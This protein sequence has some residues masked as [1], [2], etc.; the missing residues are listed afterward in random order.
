MEHEK[1]RN[2]FRPNLLPKKALLLYLFVMF[3]Q[4]VGKIK[5]QQPIHIKHNTYHVP[6]QGVISTNDL[7][8]LVCVIFQLNMEVDMQF[9]YQHARSEKFIHHIYDILLCISPRKLV[10]R[11][12]QYVKCLLQQYKIEGYLPYFVFRDVHMSRNIATKAPALA[13][14][15][16]QPPSSFAELLHFV[17]Y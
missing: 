6:H 9:F 12:A 3:V 8:Q 10:Q 1:G 7:A 4:T 17:M 2:L 11:V 13:Q 15:L 14:Y 16:G 5:L